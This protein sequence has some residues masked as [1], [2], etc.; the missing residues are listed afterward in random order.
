MDGLGLGKNDPEHNPL[1]RYAM[2]NL[3]Q[4]L[5]GNK[6]IAGTEPFEGKRATLV[7][8]DA[9]LG[10]EGLP[11][12]ATG[13]G[14]LITGKNISQMIGEHYGPKPNEPV[15]KIIKKN[16]LFMS[17]MK[18]GYS[19]ALLNGYP[20][21]YFQGIES[22]RRLLSSI[23][24]AVTSAGIQLKT[25]K[26]VFNG[27]AMSVDFTGKSWRDQLG[28]TDYPVML[29]E[30]AGEKLAEL[31]LSYDLAFFEFW[32][33]DYVGHHQDHEVA[34]FMLENFDLVLGGLI[35]KWPDE[36][37]LILITSDHGNMEDLSIRKHTSNPVPAL[38]IGDVATRRKFVSNLKDLS[39][40]MPAILQFYP[41]IK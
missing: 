4:L 17:L 19:S 12:S 25:E 26:D 34:Q 22:G 27:A 31:S 8:I 6:L 29:P 35:K 2:P 15:R 10:V 16:N 38:V 9:N 21:R 14:A 30:E 36:D 41:S 28:Y 18:S 11:Q 1:V 24:L 20:P 13:Q 39:D 23:P 37:G 5:G 33:S 3:E 40:I 7:G 32:I